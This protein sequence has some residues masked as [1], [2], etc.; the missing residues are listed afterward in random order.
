MRAATT[1]SSTT[2]ATM[3]MR[4]TVTVT[5][6]PFA[7]QGPRREPAKRR[8]LPQGAVRPP[9]VQREANPKQAGHGRAGGSVP[10]RPA[11]GLCQLSAGEDGLYL[12]YW[13]GRLSLRD[14]IVYLPD[15]PPIQRRLR[16]PHHRHFHLIAAPP[17]PSG[18]YLTG[19]PRPTRPFRHQRPPVPKRPA[20]LEHSKLRVHD[21]SAHL[22]VHRRLVRALQPEERL[23]V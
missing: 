14:Q 19:K 17:Q 23:Q 12:G 9:P 18:A 21:R 8:A 7:G 10:P 13:V 6:S 15:G 5:V 11:Q 16:H 1:S 3:T 4:V 22:K 20:V 2:I